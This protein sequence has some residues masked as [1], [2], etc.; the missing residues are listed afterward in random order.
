MCSNLE[1]KDYFGMALPAT[2]NQL[3]CY[4]PVLLF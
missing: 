4:T 3:N 1:L 2:P